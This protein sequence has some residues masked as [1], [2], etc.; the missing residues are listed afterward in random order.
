MAKGK[1]RRLGWAQWVL[2]MLLGGLLGS[3][4]AALGRSLLGEGPLVSAL[5]RSWTVGLNPPM[6]LDLKVIQL[7]FGLSFDVGLLTL[8]GVLLSLWIYWKVR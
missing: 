5:T 1:S 7:T 2:V 8:V 6:T 4:L 3:T